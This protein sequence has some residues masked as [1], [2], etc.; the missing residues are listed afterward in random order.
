[1]AGQKS[2]IVAWV[3]TEIRCREAN[4]KGE[5][6]CHRLKSQ[7]ELFMPT[8]PLA[9]ILLEPASMLRNSLWE[10]VSGKFV[11]KRYALPKW[12]LW[13]RLALEFTRTMPWLSLI[14]G[15][16][17]LSL[18]SLNWSEVALGCSQHRFTSSVSTKRQP[19]VFAGVGVNRKTSK[20]IIPTFQI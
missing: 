10:M 9:C 12:F 3:K 17:C 15:S 13:T 11:F 5:K 16:F 20:V 14:T 2:H 1:M 18:S 19:L 6:F 8:A 7:L 4:G